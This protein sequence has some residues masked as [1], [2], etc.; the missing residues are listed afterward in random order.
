LTAALQRAAFARLQNLLAWS[1]FAAA[2]IMIAGCAAVTPPAPEP[3][4]PPKQW[5]VGELLK[6]LSERN[7]QFRSLRT[8]ARLDY[9]GPDGKG[10]VQEAVLVQ[11]PDRL[12]LETLTFLGAVL[13]VTVNDQEIIGH[14]PREGIFVRGPRTKENLLRY[15]QIPLELSEITALLLGLPPVDT[16]AAPRQEGPTLVF[17]AKGRKQD[18][19][20]FESQLPVPTK[21]ERFND[22]G[23]MEL[24]ARFLDY[25]S[26]PAGSFPSKIQI[27]AQ[28]QKRKLE[29]RYQQPEI[30][31]SLPPEIFTQD[32]PAHAQELQL[33]T[34]GG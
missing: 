33:E 16:G 8:L 12:R 19:V 5:E 10:N 14:H 18:A 30:N 26:T 28:L 31:A 34:L 17:S 13:I 6:S 22:A 27:E 2:C 32:K 9:A 7:Q 15:T 20:T 25:I 4:A 24:S 1:F 3:Q 23:A 29:I 21:W 11:R